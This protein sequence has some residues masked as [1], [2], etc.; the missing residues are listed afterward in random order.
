[1]APRNMKNTKA[2]NQPTDLDELEGVL[3]N[4]HVQARHVGARHAGLRAARLRE[5]LE[6][7][8]G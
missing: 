8:V 6:A 4:G 1:M 3:V 7:P 2:T 5:Q